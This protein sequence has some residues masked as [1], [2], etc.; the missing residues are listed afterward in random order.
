[1]TDQDTNTDDE[2]DGEES[3]EKQLIA[4]LKATLVAYL[5]RVRGAV[6]QSVGEIAPQL[7]GMFSNVHVPAG[8]VKPLLL[9]GVL[10]VA[11]IAVPAAPFGSGDAG[12]SVEPETG[13]TTVDVDDEAQSPTPDTSEPSGTADGSDSGDEQPTYRQVLT[14]RVEAPGTA[15]AAPK[16]VQTS[17]GSQ[18]MAVKTGVVDGEPA[19]MLEDDRTHD[20]RWVAID[21]SWF[22]QH[23]GQ[24]PARAYIDHETNGSYSAPITVQGGSAAFYVE[25]FSSNTVTFDGELQV[26]A[27]SATDGDTI[28]YEAPNGGENLSVE[29]TGVE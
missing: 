18:T 8:A 21:T 27:E 22:E 3:N 23:L 14:S 5:A 26:S 20:G 4:W 13:N 2:S 25:G 6:S 15:P 9:A 29:L 10:L 7:R 28:T 16:Q 24:V 19:I 1:M 12:P 11:A 17:A